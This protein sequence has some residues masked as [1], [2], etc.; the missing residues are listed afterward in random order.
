M[1]GRTRSQDRVAR[2]PLDDDDDDGYA[3]LSV[4]AE[5][6][7]QVAVAAILPASLPVCLPVC[8]IVCL[9][10]FKY[11]RLALHPFSRVRNA[12]QLTTAYI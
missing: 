7:A 5:R 4:Y 6:S 12:L 3:R 2:R 9:A 11:A 1:A 10:R 8:Q